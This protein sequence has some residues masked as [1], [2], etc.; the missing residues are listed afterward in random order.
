MCTI[1][2]VA[3]IA[4]FGP[5][6]SPQQLYQAGAW[7][8]A[9]LPATEWWRAATASFMHA[10]PVHFLLNMSF[11][12]ILGPKLEQAIGV[13]PMA[14]AFALAIP[15]GTL[16][17]TLIDPNVVC[18]G[19]SAM[20]YSIMGVWLGWDPLANTGF[21]AQARILVVLNIG[22]TLTIPNISL[23][24]HLGGLLAGII[25][26]L[27]LE[28]H[29]WWASRRR[30]I[31]HRLRP[32]LDTSS[33]A[34][35]SFTKT[36]TARLAIGFAPLLVLA[37]VLYA[38]DLDL[39]AEFTTFGILVLVL[40]TLRAKRLPAML[41]YGV[42]GLSMTLGKAQLQMEWSRID[43]I[44]VLSHPP[45]RRAP[46]AQLVGLTYTDTALNTSPNREHLLR[47]QRLVGAHTVL[48]RIA[49]IPAQALASQ[50]S[51]LRQ[52]APCMVIEG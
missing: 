3:E 25:V 26:G 20:L 8:T 34:T 21:G 24:A 32:D 9:H 48:P 38:F 33:V 2:F 10:N 22:L 29:T 16:G 50:L 13:I 19:A 23:G 31:R 41:S 52:S 1:Y 37:A 17:A 46:R 44:F 47:N 51:Q 14:A 30:V 28:R 4:L 40:M 42:D 7:F 49:D 12:L 45:R 35:H 18:V 15:L 11:L 6:P 39:G 36:S 43:N 27:S 5:S